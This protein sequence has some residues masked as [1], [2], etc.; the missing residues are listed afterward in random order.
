MKK[1]ISVTQIIRHIIQ[2]AAFILFPG[3]F[4]T[5]FS[6]L[7][8]IYTAIIGGTFSASEYASQILLLLAISP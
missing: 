4:I 6:A 3:L 8:G 2:L 5:T 1:K 7:R